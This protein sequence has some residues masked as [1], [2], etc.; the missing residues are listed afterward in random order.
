MQFAGD[1]YVRTNHHTDICITN[2]FTT[3]S[4]PYYPPAIQQKQPQLSFSAL[5]KRYSGILQ[6]YAS[7]FSVIEISYRIELTNKIAQ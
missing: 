7:F 4:H 5:A 2:Q 6:K 3:P 1:R